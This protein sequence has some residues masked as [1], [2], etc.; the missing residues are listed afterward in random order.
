GPA[1]DFA[2]AK[3]LD[4]DRAARFAK[5]F[6]RHPAFAYEEE[7]VGFL[8]FLEDHVTPWETPVRSAARQCLQI[9]GVEPF[10]EGMFGQ[11][12]LKRVHGNPFPAPWR[13]L[14][15]LP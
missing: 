11:Q 2:R 10:K 6:D 3:S 4:R 8:A 15:A 5:D 14:R 12:R 1:E 13:G 9:I 7:L